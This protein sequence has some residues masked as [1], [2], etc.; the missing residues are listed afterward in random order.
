MNAI[1]ER[2]ASSLSK[3]QQEVVTLFTEEKLTPPEIA[4]RLSCKAGNVYQILRRDDVKEVILAHARSLLGLSAYSA[5]HTL[6]KLSS[7]AKSEFVQLEAS[8][9]LLDRAGLSQP[10]VNHPALAIQINLDT[11]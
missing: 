7:G 6:T 8:K 2:K 10:E 5:A 1:A 3:R 4:E 9:A 11:K